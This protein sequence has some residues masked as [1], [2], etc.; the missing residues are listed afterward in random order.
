[1]KSVL[2]QFTEFLVLGCRT[3]SPSCQRQQKQEGGSSFDQI[4]VCFILCCSFSVAKSNSHS[5]MSLMRGPRT[6]EMQQSPFRN[7]CYFR[8]QVSKRDLLKKSHRQGKRTDKFP[9]CLTKLLV[10]LVLS[11]WMIDNNSFA[12]LKLHCFVCQQ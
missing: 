6:E 2:A 11:C 5:S 7:K 9:S 3:S 8:K 1:M 12:V 4:L 10:L